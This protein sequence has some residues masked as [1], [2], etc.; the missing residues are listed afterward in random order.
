MRYVKARTSAELDTLTY[1][2]FI[3]EGMRLA[4]NLNKN[5]YRERVE[6]HSDA[7]SMPQRTDPEEIKSSIFGKL[8]QMEEDR[9]REEEA[10]NGDDTNGFTSQAEDG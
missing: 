9:K 7:Q 10:Q 2:L 5:P 3:T 4:Y 8:K 6:S 1:R